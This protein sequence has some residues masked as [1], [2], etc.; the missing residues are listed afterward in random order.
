[1]GTY[2][3]MLNHARPQIRTAKEGFYDS[4]MPAMTLKNMR[5]NGATS[6]TASCE[7][8]HHGSVNVDGWPDD[9]EVPNV[10]WRLRCSKCG[11]RPKQTVPDW[12]VRRGLPD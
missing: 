12:P 8:G 9:M 10:K 4:R 5:Y 11:A 2:G 7:C 6:V 1:M 3:K